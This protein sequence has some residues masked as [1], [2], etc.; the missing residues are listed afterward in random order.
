MPSD[1]QIGWG[2]AYCVV[3][4]PVFNVERYDDNDVAFAAWY[5]RHMAL[6]EQHIA[7]ADSVASERN[8]ALTIFPVGKPVLDFEDW[9]H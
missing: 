8:K 1:E 7:L 3:G 4:L 9:W 6:A 2:R 5:R